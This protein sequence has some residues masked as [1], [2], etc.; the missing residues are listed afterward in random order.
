M[1]GF[2]FNVNTE[3]D[4]F[5]NIIPC[6]IDDKPVTS[7][8]KELRKKVNIREVKELLKEN[9]SELFDVHLISSISSELAQS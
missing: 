3:L 9:F 2:A 8:S 4:Y 6:G 7:M 5:K 1:H